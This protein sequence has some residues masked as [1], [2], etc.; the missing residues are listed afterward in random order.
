MNAAVYNYEM[1]EGILGVIL[2]K[3]SIIYHV[4]ELIKK[5]DFYRVDYRLAFE[6]MQNMALAGKSIDILNLA[7]EL[8]KT[9]KMSFE[10]SVRLSQKLGNCEATAAHVD[11]YCKIVKEHSRRRQLIDIARIAINDA[12]D[13]TKD[14]GE[15]ENR[16]Q[17]A[18]TDAA[19]MNNND[20]LYDTRR[21]VLAFQDDID[22]RAKGEGIGVKT[23][24]RSLDE[25]IGDMEAGNLVVIAAR[26]SH[27][28]SALACTIAV[29]N[30]RAGKRVLW[31]SLEMNVVET[32]RRIISQLSGVDSKKFKQPNL[33]GMTEGETSRY[34][35]A[36]DEFDKMPLHLC[37]TTNLT[38]MDIWNM[39]KAIQAKEGIDLVIVDYIGL[40]TAEKE[41]N[42]RSENR[43]QEVSK[44]TRQLKNMAGALHVPVIALSQLNR[45]N[46]KE[47]RP[48]RASDLR[49]SG[50]IEQD[51]NTIMLIQR[52]TRLS[53]DNKTVEL[54]NTATIDIAK[55]RDCGKVGKI[56]LDFFGECALFADHVE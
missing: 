52:D 10:E 38:P 33:E 6:V 1:E 35:M 5:Q 9:G 32:T 2:I 56:K 28:K 15:V 11:E 49:D 22:A 50:S 29:N 16:L 39:A 3:P 55:V 31:F 46:E 17:A 7:E 8:R 13:R 45:S 23:G 51:A 19:S 14:I 26:P 44:I 27:G 47:N 37:D 24:I 41:K 48:P 43:T 30:L 54:C 34:I 20:G 36:M 4:S 12:A 21:A 25:H 18:L 40:L 53:G 42:A